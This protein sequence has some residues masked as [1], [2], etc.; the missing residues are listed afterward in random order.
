MR[1]KRGRPP[2]ALHTEEPSPA[3][4]RGLRPRRNIK[5]KF[6]DSG[7]EDA[8]SPSREATKPARKKKAPPSARGRGR[9]RGGGGGRGARGGG[10]GGRRRTAP[11]PKTVVYDDHESEEDEDAVSLRS[12][13]D[14]LVEEAQSEEEDEGLK[15]DSDCLEDDG[16]EEEEEDGASVC[17]ESS[18][19][20]QSTHTSTP[21]KQPRAHPA[22]CERALPGPRLPYAGR[23]LLFKMENA[24][25]MKTGLVQC[26]LT[27]LQVDHSQ[28]LLLCAPESPRGYTQFTHHENKHKSSQ[29]N[30]GC[31]MLM[32]TRNI[33]S[34]LTA[35][36]NLM[37]HLCFFQF[38]I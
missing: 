24:H 28:D 30:W 2:K 14:E 9:G 29:N 4:T 16:Q 13:E 6:K 36:S 38:S 5:P 3:A 32:L 20:S 35:L 37:T 17:T 11:K 10:R 33:S 8:E 15:E 25:F 1:G 27:S 23:S 31:S 19:R 7:D 12:E 26:S 18:F 22:G 21:G 34:V